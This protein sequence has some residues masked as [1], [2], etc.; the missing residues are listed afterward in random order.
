[1]A[2]SLPGAASR[3]TAHQ[4]HRNP[5]GV[6][7]AQLQ[8]QPDTIVQRQPHLQLQWNRLADDLAHE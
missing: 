4:Q 7:D 1:M 3:Y 2:A 8:L 5:H 6:G